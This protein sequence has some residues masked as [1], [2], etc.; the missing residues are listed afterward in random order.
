M[1]KFDFS[2]MWTWII[3]HACPVTYRKETDL[4]EQLFWSYL[5]EENAIFDAARISRIKS[6]R[7][8]LPRKMVALYNSRGEYVAALRDEVKTLLALDFADAPG[9]LA[10]LIDMI[11]SDETISPVKRRNLL[12]GSVVDGW[13]PPVDWVTDMICYSMLPRAGA[14]ARNG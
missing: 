12:R 6:G 7:E 10:E 4:F 2:A 5:R 9:A 8:R 14:P 13:E 1:S 3:Q 11:A